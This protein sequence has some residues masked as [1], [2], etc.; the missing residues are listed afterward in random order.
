VKSAQTVRKSRVFRALICKVRE[1][2]LPDPPQ[3]LKLAGINKLRN[4]LAL[5][6]IGLQ[7]N[8]IVYRISVYSFGQS[9]SPRWRVKIFCQFRSN[10]S[11]INK[12]T[13]YLTDNRSLEVLMRKGVFFFVFVLG[14]FVSATLSTSA[15]DRNSV[16]GFVFDE[17]RRPVAQIYI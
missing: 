17:S 10:L 4:K 6:R 13:L 2:E 8:N 15:Q 5:S 3:T 11:I 9:V 7:P 16:S 14:I 12:R 1:T